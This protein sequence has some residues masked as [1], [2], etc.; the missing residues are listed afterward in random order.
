MTLAETGHALLD[1]L[2]GGCVAMFIFAAGWFA[3]RAKLLA[4]RLPER[5]SEPLNDCEGR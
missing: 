2:A 5:F 3:G 4:E 1:I